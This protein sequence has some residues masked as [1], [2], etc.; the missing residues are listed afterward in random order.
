MAFLVVAGRVWAGPNLFEP[1][2][3]V[4]KM[5]IAILEATRYG[6]VGC[7][8]HKVIQRRGPTNALQ[9]HLFLL[10]QEYLRDQGQ[11]SPCRVAGKTTRRNPGREETLF[12]PRVVQ[13]LAGT[14][15][16]G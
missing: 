13:I 16:P 2:V 3:P 5:G 9:G 12:L 15:G 8:L 7:L 14:A 4:V 6:R 11:H 1:Q 10:A